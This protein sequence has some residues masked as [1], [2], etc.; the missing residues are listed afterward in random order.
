MII[1]DLY[2]D[3]L[4]D[5][6]NLLII[7][8]LLIIII[9]GGYNKAGLIPTLALISSFV[10][11]FGTI[12]CI[13]ELVIYIL[14]KDKLSRKFLIVAIAYIVSIIYL[15]YFQYYLNLTM[16]FVSGLFIILFMFG[17]KIFMN[18]IRGH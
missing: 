7:V 3:F 12:A 1:D 16:M 13:S 11:L 4:K 6:T 18:R 15:L 10:C 9:I 5:K 8:V 17:I 2:K 14:K